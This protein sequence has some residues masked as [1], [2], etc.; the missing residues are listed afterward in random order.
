MSGSAARRIATMFEWLELP[1]VALLGGWYTPDA[2]FKD[3]FHEVRGLPAIQRIYTHMFETLDTPRFRVS[4]VFEH[5]SDCVLVW[6]MHFRFRSAVRGPQ[7]V[8]G[9]TQL[10]LAPDGRIEWHR[11]YWDAA[12]ELYAKLPVLGPFT[13]W[14]QRR[15]GAA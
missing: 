11:D 13:R 3:P 14:L 12:E 6:E 4:H 2:Y 5:G 10:R 7:V 1:D 15:M 8:R 9:T